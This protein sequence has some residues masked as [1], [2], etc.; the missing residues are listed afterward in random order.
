MVRRHLHA[1]NGHNVKTVRFGLAT[2]TQKASFNHTELNFAISRAIF[3]F[4]TKRLVNDNNENIRR[5]PTSAVTK[6]GVIM[7]TS[8]HVLSIFIPSI[9]HLVLK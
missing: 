9:F 1:P 5:E 3:H 4:D 7:K 8:W 6:T 2:K